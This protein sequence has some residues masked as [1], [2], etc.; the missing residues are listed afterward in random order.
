MKASVESPLRPTRAPPAVGLSRLVRAF[1]C[2][3]AGLR[4]AWQHEPSVR[5]ELL[6]GVVLVPLAFLLPVSLDRSLMLVAALVPILVVELLNSAIEALADAV[7]EEYHPLIGR[8]KDIGSA[9]VLVTVLGA[10]VVWLAI[11]V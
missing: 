11:L 7:S 2:S 1:H 9:A 4:A 6:L 5:L 10:V 3:V 8:A